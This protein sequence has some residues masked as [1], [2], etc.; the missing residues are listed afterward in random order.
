MA[1]QAKSSQ[2]QR[3]FVTLSYRFHYRIVEHHKWFEKI[4]FSLSN[5]GVTRDCWSVW[6][7]DKRAIFG[8]LKIL[9]DIYAFDAQYVK[10]VKIAT[11]RHYLPIHLK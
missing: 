9:P 6:H 8:S 11:R 2:I 3:I 7:K 5:L 4:Q 1:F 10:H